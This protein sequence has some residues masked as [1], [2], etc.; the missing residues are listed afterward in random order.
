MFEQ[1]FDKPLASSGIRPGGLGLTQR[2]ISLSKLHAGSRVLD[3]G[4]G[5]GVSIEHLLCKH[6]I[7]AVGIDLSPVLVTQGRARVPTLPLAIGDA[8]ALP[9]ADGSFDGIVLECTLSLVQDHEA[10]LS[11]CHRVLSPL[12][13]IILT[14]LYVR[15]PDAIDQLRRLPLQSCL[16]GAL[17]KDEFLNECSAAG[18]GIACWEDHSNLLR[19]FAVQMIWTYGSLAQFWAAM[20]GCC[21]DPAEIHHAVQQARPGYFLYVGGKVG[22]PW[23]AAECDENELL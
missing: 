8:E 11:E 3:V 2:A 21:A 10:V 12:G 22:P 19:E 15:N 9:F 17:H 16:R 6:G 13:T 23:P 18:F 7:P 1:V 5:T 20:G 14:D 4:C